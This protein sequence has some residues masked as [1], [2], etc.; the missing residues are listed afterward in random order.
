MLKEKGFLLFKARLNKHQ[1]AKL[2]YQFKAN[3]EIYAE[4]LR[5]E[6]AR[7]DNGLLATPRMLLEA[8]AKNYINKEGYEKGDYHGYEE[9]ADLVYVDIFKA[10]QKKKNLRPIVKEGS[11]LH[12]VRANE[13]H[14]IYNGEALFLPRLGRIDIR[15]LRPL[16]FGVEI[17][18]V[19]FMQ[20]PGSPIEIGVSFYQRK[21]L[22]Q[23][24]NVII[25]NQAAG[26]RSY[27]RGM[28]LPKIQD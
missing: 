16:P 27:I 20:K 2:Y 1:L 5:Q 9:M 21:K 26:S 24:I 25:T 10:R 8:Q 17:I 22:G 28:L 6:R 18:S 14:L 3:A 19:I 13:N 4:L 23:P 11:N 7:M 12:I 15:G